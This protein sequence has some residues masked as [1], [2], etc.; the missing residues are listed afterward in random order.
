MNIKLQIVIRF[1]LSLIFASLLMWGLMSLWGKL[2]VNGTST[3]NID[4][5]YEKK[6]FFYCA[7]RSLIL[8][9][10]ASIVS[11]MFTLF[12]LFISEKVSRLRSL[13]IINQIFRTSV[14]SIPC[15]FVAY[16]V[17]RMALNLDISLSYDDKASLV[18]N[19][20]CFILP[21]LI[22]GFSDGLLNEFINSSEAEVNAIKKESYLKMGKI[23]GAN[24][25]MYIWRDYTLRFSRI[26]LMKFSALISGAV[27]IEYIFRIPGLGW[28]AFESAKSQNVFQL[29]IILSLAVFMVFLL[30]F[31]YYFLSIFLDPRLR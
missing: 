4:L 25:F 27:I 11:L 9:C 2:H 7:I 13:N 14:S 3:Y 10:F 19:W 20:Y 12:S 5:S 30:N 1:V 24:I 18:Q 6:I 17:I 21:V 15:I 29:M 16:F 22:L 8:I 26:Y 28:L 23:I 31:L